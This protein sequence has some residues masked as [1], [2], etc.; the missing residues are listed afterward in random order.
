MKGSLRL[1]NDADLERAAPVSD[2]RLSRLSPPGA[3]LSVCFSPVKRGDG[4][5]DLCW[6][7]EA[8]LCHS[9]PDFATRLTA[10]SASNAS[11]PKLPSLKAL[12]TV[13]AP[14]LG[15]FVVFFRRPHDPLSW[16][17]LSHLACYVMLT[18]T[19]CLG[20]NAAVTVGHHPVYC[21]GSFAAENGATSSTTPVANDHGD[22]D[23]MLCRHSGLLVSIFMFIPYSL[24]G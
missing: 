9:Q 7:E 16:S 13:R 8:S 12:A 20:F 14:L 15:P 1:G 22:G 24:A 5:A 4:R 21:F 2:P 6:W 10:S 19:V 18:I 23:Q 11:S 3:K 17:C